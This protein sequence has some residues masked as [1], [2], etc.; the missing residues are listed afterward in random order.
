[1]MNGSAYSQKSHGFEEL[2]PVR[3]V[4]SEV[5]SPHGL[6]V[7]CFRPELCSDLIIIEQPTDEDLAGLLYNAPEGRRTA[8]ED[9]RALQEREMRRLL[10]QA[11]RRAI[12]SWADSQFASVWEGVH[13]QLSPYLSP[14]VLE[15]V[16]GDC[17][18]IL[19]F[20]AAFGEQY[21]FW[22]RVWQCYHLCT[23]PVGWSGAYPS[24]SLIATISSRQRR[25]GVGS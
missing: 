18:S 8:W 22:E 9:V 21:G 13:R 19:R 24:G 4:L 3:Q 5:V 23:Y 6:P 16:V 25:E 17:I 20:R 1:M 2:D 10:S 7:N 15:V 11:Q 12:N 14:K